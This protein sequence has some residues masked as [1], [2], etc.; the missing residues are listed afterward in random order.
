M[1]KIYKATSFSFGSTYLAHIVP[2]HWRGAEECL[3]TRHFP[4]SPRDP[5]SRCGTIAAG[6]TTFL[7]PGALTG[8]LLKVCKLRCNW[9]RNAAAAFLPAFC[10][11]S[12]QSATNPALLA[13]KRSAI[14][15]AEI[16]GGGAFLCAFWRQMLLW[17]RGISD[18]S[19]VPC[20]CDKMEM[21]WHISE[22]IWE[23][24]VGSAQ[25]EFSMWTPDEKRSCLFLSAMVNHH[26]I[27]PTIWGICLFFTRTP[28]ANPR[29]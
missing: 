28:K 6:S 23:F 7:T 24:C 4:G 14:A 16:S 1:D 22:S 8:G 3:T 26:E 27:K 13:A 29:I 25:Q 5:H 15:M 18:S 17:G 10:F 19:N 20:T 2:D 12:R 21:V 9:Q 11:P